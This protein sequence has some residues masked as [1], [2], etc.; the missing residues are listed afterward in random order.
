[1]SSDQS[2]TS[3]SQS[4]TT[5]WRV[6]RKSAAIVLTIV[7][8]V[9]LGSVYA[10]GS[11]TSSSKSIPNPTSL[12]D[13]ATSTTLTSNHPV[14]SGYLS[15]GSDYVAFIQWNNSNGIVNGTEQLVTTSGQ[16]PNLTTNNQTVPVSGTITGSK[17]SLSLGLNA[18]V[19]GTFSGN[20]MTINIPQQDGTL[21]PVIFKKANTV[22]YNNAVNAL[23]GNESFSNSQAI[24]AQQTAN[25]E[26]K[27]TKD[28]KIVNTDLAN[29]NSSQLSTDSI[30]VL[31]ALHGE[32]K[33]LAT[34][35]TEEQK[36]LSEVN[37]VSNFQVCSD[38]EYKV[39]NDA[40]YKVASDAQYNVESTATYGV[41]E[42]AQSL[43]GGI[44]QLKADF[45]QLQTDEQTLPSFTP[46]GT[47]TQGQIN[48]AISATS[49]A[50]STALSTTNG[51]ITQANAY[52]T[53][54]FQ[55][56][57][58]AYKAGNCGTPPTVPSPQKP[59]S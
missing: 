5:W 47:P 7:I 37:T 25:V 53:T 59:I 56:V 44:Q 30:G 43:E 2:P 45:S 1:M 6:S 48:Q 3:N 15:T 51:N 27:I 41:A 35:K 17:I 55:Y 26:G 20:S 21:A 40:I 36:V 11:H 54:A 23:H 57:D 28:V 12:F 22:A 18:N 24:Q 34:T 46:Q 10:L 52:V 13:S 19:F 50:I 31:A 33:A 39:G 32:A 14:G 38:A 4:E 42:D 16:A 8:V 58:Q 49:V 9:I 29:L